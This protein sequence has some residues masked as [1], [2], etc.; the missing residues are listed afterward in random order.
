MKR[1]NS[2][3]FFEKIYMCYYYGHK[4]A[5]SIDF[6]KSVIDQVFFYIDRKNELEIV[7]TKLMKGNLDNLLKKFVF[8]RINNFNNNAKLGKEDQEILESVSG[9]CELYPNEKNINMI[10]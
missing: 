1:I 8:N 3:I 6:E 7:K 5:Y 10:K 4:S 9:I 2:F